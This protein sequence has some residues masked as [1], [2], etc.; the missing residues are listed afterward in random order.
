MHS[1]VL[2]LHLS[3]QF[4]GGQGNHIQLPYSEIVAAKQEIFSDFCSHP[5]TP[6]G[7][8]RGWSTGCGVC[9][10]QDSLRNSLSTSV[11]SPGKVKV[12]GIKS[13][14]HM[15]LQ[16]F[17]K[18]RLEESK[19]QMSLPDFKCGKAG[20]KASHRGFSQTS[21]KVLAQGAGEEQ[22]AQV[23]DGPSEHTAVGKSLCRLEVNIE[24]KIASTWVHSLGRSISMVVQTR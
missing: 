3:V 8:F 7:D 14:Q 1:Y 19:Q 20:E 9:I 13:K 2:V 4:T 24:P 23:C 12:Q 16:T 11:P 15:S 17:Q 22:A 18:A 10:L 6:A 21:V 5:D